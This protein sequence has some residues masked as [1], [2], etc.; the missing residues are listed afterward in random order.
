DLAQSFEKELRLF[1]AQLRN[2]IAL[3]SRTT[4]K[5]AAEAITDNLNEYMATK[6]KGDLLFDISEREAGMLQQSIEQDSKKAWQRFELYRIQLAEIEQQL[7]QA[8]AN[9]A[10]APEDEQLMDLFEKLRDLDKQRENQRQK[11]LSLLE[12]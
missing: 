6:P 5:I 9:I 7:E 3:R 11:Y 4:S 12:D 2:D 8:A 1:L 10:R